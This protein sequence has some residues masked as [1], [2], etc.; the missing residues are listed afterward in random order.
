M[1][2]PTKAAASLNPKH[3]PGRGASDELDRVR[4]SRGEVP[5]GALDE[6]PVRL[7]ESP[8]RLKG[9]DAQ[10]AP[11]EG[12]CASVV[13]LLKGITPNPSFLYRWAPFSL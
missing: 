10:E 11:L 12:A 1:L 13:E 8:R 4:N 9:A 2:S 6:Q 3:E 5:R 7:G